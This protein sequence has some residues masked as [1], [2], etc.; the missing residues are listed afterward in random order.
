MLELYSERRVPKGI[1]RERLKV[2][3]GAFVRMSIA[4]PLLIMKRVLFATA[5]MLGFIN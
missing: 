2:N 4:S 3:F 1:E 5:V